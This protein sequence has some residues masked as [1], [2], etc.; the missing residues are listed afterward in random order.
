M[1]QKEK[2][3]K[4]ACIACLFVGILCIVSGVMA[5]VR[6][7]DLDA[8]ATLL[9]GVIGLPVGVQTARLANVPSNAARIQKVALIVTLLTIGLAALAFCA[10]DPTSLQIAA[11]ACA[12]LVGLAMT[13][14]SHVLV[15]EQAKV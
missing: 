14:F 3:L 8:A 9:G 12:I 4:L 15:R 6:A 1:N 2:N 5:A 13:V 7:L 10:G 11:L